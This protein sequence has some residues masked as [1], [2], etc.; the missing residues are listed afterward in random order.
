LIKINIFIFDGIP[1]EAALEEG[2]NPFNG[3]IFSN[4]SLSVEA[5]SEVVSAKDITGLTIETCRVNSTALI[6]GFLACEGEIKTKA[7]IRNCSFASS[8]VSRGIF[9]HF[10]LHA[11]GAL[12]KDGFPRAKFEDTVNIFVSIRKMM[13][14]TNI[15]Q[16]LVPEEAFCSG[17]QL[18]NEK[19]RG[20]I[21]PVKA[22][23]QFMKK[24]V[25]RVS[26]FRRCRISTRGGTQR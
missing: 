3:S 16:L 7:L 6:L 10:C 22:G 1:G 8:V 21:F 25:C 9:L 20:I 14:V 4:T 26:I 5:T 2:T 17:I 15:V 23:C 13:L 12:A 24:S 19:F 11:D 18:L